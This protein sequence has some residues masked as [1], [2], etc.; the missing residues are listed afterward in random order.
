MAVT[1]RYF[2][3]F[4]KPVLQHIT[5]PICGEIYGRVYCILL[6]VYYVV[7]K[8]VHVRYLI[9]WW[10]FLLSGSE[11]GGGQIVL[12]PF[13]FWPNSLPPV[14]VFQYRE[15]MMRVLHGDVNSTAGVFADISYTVVSVCCAL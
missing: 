1:L 7:V 8:K 13:Y 4:G 14:L 10:V 6:C 15:V 11:W 5:A 2:T 9:S 12:P 3:E